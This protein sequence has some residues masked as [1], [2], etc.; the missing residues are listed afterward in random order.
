[1][2]RPNQ[3]N[4]KLL[5][6]SPIGLVVLAAR[7]CADSVDMMEM[8]PTADTMTKD[9]R[10][11][12]EERVLK[13]DRPPELMDPPHES[14]LEHLYYTFELE[15]SRGVLQEIARH[16]I[17]SP[18]VQST[19]YALK[20]LVRK[21]DNGGKLDDLLMYTGDEDVDK[22]IRTCAEIL[23]DA[24]RAKKP[25]DTAKFLVGDWMRT[26]CVFTINARSLRNLLVL[27]TSKHALWQFRQLAYAIVDQIPASHWFLYDRYVH[28]R[29]DWC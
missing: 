22:G 24:V 29:P 3:V 1:M 6:N 9:D 16:R 5:H 18:S 21:L 26:K 4:A 17:A 12:L 14:V 2:N 20:K 8:E 23:A 10:R 7:T 15:F 25:N 27:R 13:L 11:L 19:R 28:L